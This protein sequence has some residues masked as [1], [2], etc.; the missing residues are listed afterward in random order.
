MKSIVNLVKISTGKFVNGSDVPT[1]ALMDSDEHIHGYLALRRGYHFQVSENI[2]GE[3]AISQSETVGLA[4]IL[5]AKFAMPADA[6]NPNLSIWCS[7]SSDLKKSI[8]RA[9]CWNALDAMEGRDVYTE[10]DDGVHSII[11]ICHTTKMYDLVNDLV[12]KSIDYLNPL[13]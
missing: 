11:Y 5:T 1:L 9:F 2:K 10:D 4:N 13:I 6:K 3:G 12:D 7:N 8:M